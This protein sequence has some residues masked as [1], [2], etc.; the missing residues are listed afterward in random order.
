[1]SLHGV[2]AQGEIERPHLI[3]NTCSSISAAQ[4]SERE[5]ESLVPRVHLKQPLPQLQLPTISTQNLSPGGGRSGEGGAEGSEAPLQPLKGSFVQEGTACSAE[6]DASHMRGIRPP[7]Q[8]ISHLE[9]V[10]ASGTVWAERWGLWL[11]SP[12]PSEVIS[13]STEALISPLSCPGWEI[14]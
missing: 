6:E 4:A 13:S 3:G 2:A 5:L 12:V 7:G 1:M 14:G 11:Q 8:H 9:G 10:P